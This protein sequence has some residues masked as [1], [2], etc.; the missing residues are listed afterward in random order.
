[1]YGVISCSSTYQITLRRGKQNNAKPKM[2]TWKHIKSGLW[3]LI[4]SPRASIL[5][6]NS[7]SSR[8]QTLYVMILKVFLS[9]W[10]PR[11]AVEEHFEFSCY[12]TKQKCTRNSLK[13]IQNAQ[14]TA[15]NKMMPEKIAGN[16]KVYTSH[17][18][19]LLS[20]SPCNR[21]M[22]TWAIGH[23]TWIMTTN[24]QLT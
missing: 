1:M 16:N 9:K 11:L 24:W 2:G 7:I 14:V 12:H 10:I 6:L 13:Q 17:A 15:W 20:G 19:I 22:A 4:R 8:N 21:N 23:T 3:C 5:L 18:S